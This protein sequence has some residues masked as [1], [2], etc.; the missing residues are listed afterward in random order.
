MDSRPNR[1]GIMV[2]TIRMKTWSFVQHRWCLVRFSLK[3][4]GGED[5]VI[6]YLALSIPLKTDSHFH[7]NL[8]LAVGQANS[9]KRDRNEKFRWITYTANLNVI[10][11]YLLMF[12]VGGRDNLRQL[13]THLF[14]CM[15][16][17]LPHL[18]LSVAKCADWV[19]I[20][21]FFVVGAGRGNP[22]EL[23][24]WCCLMIGN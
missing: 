11:I 13:A 6:N 24:M 18:P 7:L 2:T 12:G 5:L 21:C 1:A 22:L 14:D 15:L 20:Y 10:F 23:D 4:R 3:F 17:G 19:E 9:N 8:N 16:P